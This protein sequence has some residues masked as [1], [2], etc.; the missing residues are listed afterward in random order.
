[1]GEPALDVDV[2]DPSTLLAE[3]F[4]GR[5]IIVPRDERGGVCFYV[6][7]RAREPAARRAALTAREREVLTRA[8]LGE[9]NKSIAISLG[10]G[11]TS[12]TTLLARARKKLADRV[13]ESVLRAL[14]AA[15]ELAAP[16]RSR[17]VPTRASFC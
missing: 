11:R 10:V 7:T 6:A 1:M 13:P 8:L 14:L 3:L 15:S 9:S 17:R 12:V 4:S 5:W 2:P 16:V